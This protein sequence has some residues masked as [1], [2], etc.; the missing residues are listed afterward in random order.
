[1]REKIKVIIENTKEKIRTTLTDKALKY[2]QRKQISEYEM[3]RRTLF[4]EDEIS[5]AE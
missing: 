2:D 1:M 4:I 5:T 3:L